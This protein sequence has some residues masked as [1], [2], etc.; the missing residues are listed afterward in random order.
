MLLQ[1]IMLFLQ[2][3]SLLIITCDVPVFYVKYSVL[4]KKWKYLSEVSVIG[5]S[6]NFFNPKDS[7]YLYLLPSLL[8]NFL[9]N[10]LELC[11][12]VTFLF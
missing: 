2:L 4:Q 12:I 3:V 7:S 6:K 10:Y 9:A 5:G 11:N 8:V 1:L